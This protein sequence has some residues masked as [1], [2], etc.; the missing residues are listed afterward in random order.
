M[1]VSDEMPGPHQKLGEAST[2]ELLPQTLF[3][4]A[5][6]RSLFLLGLLN[7]FIFL[8]FF[9]TDLGLFMNKIGRSYIDKN[10]SCK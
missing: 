6:S 7:I 8:C 5:T 3:Y 10:V 4:S 2:T 1:E 9:F